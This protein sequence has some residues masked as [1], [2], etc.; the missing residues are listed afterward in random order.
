MECFG[1]WCG[2]HLCATDTHSHLRFCLQKLFDCCVAHSCSQYT[3]EATRSTTTLKMSE[4]T[5]FYVKLRK[6]FFHAFCNMI[7]ASV[8]IT[9]SDNNDHRTFFAFVGKRQFLYQLVDAGIFFG[10]QD[11]FCTT[12]HTRVKRDTS[13]I[14]T[15]HLH[16]KH[17]TV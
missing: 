14:T 11:G 5:S 16:E 9:F 12:S 7:S 4:Y 8:F 13:R 1:Q 10:E 2:N 6:L 3:V 17:A 15:H